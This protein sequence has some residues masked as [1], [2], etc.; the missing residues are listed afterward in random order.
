MHFT[1]FMFNEAV[2]SLFDEMES[3]KIGESSQLFWLENTAQPL[4]QDHWVLEKT[5]KVYHDIVIPVYNIVSLSPLDQ[6]GGH[7]TD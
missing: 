5:G 4:R 6:T 3:R 2:V 1:Y 7:I